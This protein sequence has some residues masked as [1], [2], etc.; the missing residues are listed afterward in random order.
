LKT[1][2][3]RWSEDLGNTAHIL[4]KTLPIALATD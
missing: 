4:M 2:F 3:H 1:D